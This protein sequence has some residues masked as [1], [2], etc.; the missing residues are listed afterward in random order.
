MKE[1]NDEIKH[2]QAL[3]SKL[4]QDVQSSQKQFTLLKSQMSALCLAIPIQP[5]ASAAASAAASQRIKRSVQRG[6]MSKKTTKKS[7]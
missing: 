4:T 6:V 5:P 7:E 2:I 3:N 1:K